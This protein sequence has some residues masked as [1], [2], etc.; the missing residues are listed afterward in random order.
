[1][2]VCALKGKLDA[3]EKAGLAPAFLK[4]GAGRIQASS[5]AGVIATDSPQ[6]HALVWLGLLNTKLDDSFSVL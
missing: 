6:P 4:F 1:V 3:Y 5:S 2:P